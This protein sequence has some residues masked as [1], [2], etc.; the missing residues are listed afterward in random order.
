M[1]ISP[2]VY[3]IGAGPGD[4]DLITVRGRDLVA[5]ADLVLYAGSLVPAKVVGCARSGAVIADSAGMSL[6]QTHALM[7]E[8]ARKGGI[9]ARVHTGDPSLFGS[10]R[11]QIALL[12]RDGVPWTI[13]PG[14][15]AA[16][17]AA[18]RAGVSFTVPG[19]DKPVTDDLEAENIAKSLFEFQKEQGI[20][21]PV[22]LVKA[23]AGGGGMGIEEVD[24]LDKFRSV[25][26]RI[27]SYSKRQFRDLGE[28]DQYVAGVLS[29]LQLQHQVGAA[30]NDP[31]F[32][33]VGTEECDRFGHSRRKNIVLN[34][35]C[36]P[37]YF[38]TRPG[39][40]YRN[41]GEQWKEHANMFVF[42]MLIFMSLLE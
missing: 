37:L 16:F 38:Q 3:F 13:I 15:T 35:S 8:T 30:G 5:Q 20:N 19:S 1:N 6:E 41:Y 14:V 24:D 31:G 7:L 18:A 2:Q 17:A 40:R 23:S 32:S 28:I 4:P 12:D 39:C 11:E 29:I 9:V 22:I 33:P 10:V 21:N 26:R 36:P 42:N 25:L 34:H 27:K